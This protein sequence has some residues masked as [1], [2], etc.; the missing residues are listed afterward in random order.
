M[1]SSTLTT[2]P[3]L[4][5][6][7]LAANRRSYSVGGS[8]QVVPHGQEIYEIGRPLQTDP[9][10]R[11]SPQAARFHR[12]VKRAPGVLAVDIAPTLVTVQMAPGANRGVV[13]QAVR[14]AL[15]VHFGWGNLPLS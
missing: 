2:T 15:R 10:A 12:K 13:D 11:A 7:D 14:A 8:W 9:L 3:R 6:R 5:C 4:V 1:Q